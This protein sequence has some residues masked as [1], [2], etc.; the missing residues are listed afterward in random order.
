V[1]GGADVVQSVYRIALR[2]LPLYL[3]K[4]PLDP[5]L[6]FVG[7]ARQ[8][9]K[10]AFEYFF[11]A[12]RRD[13]RRNEALPEGSNAHPVAGDQSLSELAITNEEIELVRQLAEGLEPN[14]REVLL[15][16]Q[17]EEKPLAEVAAALGITADAAAQRVHRA[18]K[19]FRSLF[20]EL[21]KFEE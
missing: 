10:S 16:Y 19:R 7:I 11:D 9:L 12:Q 4:P 15:L 21:M 3:D 18:R 20:Q 5:Y 13:F 17:F 2:Q 1:L 8:R 14:D 6:W